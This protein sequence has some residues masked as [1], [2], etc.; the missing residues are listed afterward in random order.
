MTGFEGSSTGGIHFN[1]ENISSTDITSLE[2]KTI[3]NIYPNPTQGREISLLYDIDNLE[4]DNSLNIFDM[5]GRI[6]KSTKLYNNGFNEKKISLEN[7]NSG[8]YLISFTNG[9]EIIRKKLIVQ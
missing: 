1:V 5:N 6:V 8:I 3:F 9:K 7:F 4:M 2:N